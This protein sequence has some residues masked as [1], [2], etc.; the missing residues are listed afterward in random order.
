MEPGEKDNED[1]KRTNG[2]GGG[3]SHDKVCVWGGGGGGGGG[4]RR[5]EGR[6]E[7]VREQSQI[8]DQWS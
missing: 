4:G 6:G 8:S 7:N 5:E 1:G 2:N 3:K